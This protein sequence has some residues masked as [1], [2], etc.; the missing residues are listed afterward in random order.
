GPAATREALSSA[1]K[2]ARKATRRHGEAARTFAP[3][4]STRKTTRRHREATRA[5]AAR[6]TTRRHHTAAA[7]TL[8]R[9]GPIPSI[10]GISGGPGHGLPIDVSG[11]SDYAK[12]HRD[13]VAILSKGPRCPS[14]LIDHGN[15][16]AAREL[17]V[18]FPVSS[19]GL[20][21]RPRAVGQVI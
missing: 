1:R 10:L 16:A 11:V 2:S 15:L 18:Q 17:E 6:K 9:Y 13:R 20:R 5:F 19:Q 3:R 14:V 8:F 4:K 7:P 21:T 12:A